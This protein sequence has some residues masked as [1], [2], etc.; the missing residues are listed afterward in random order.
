MDAYLVRKATFSDGRTRHNHIWDEIAKEVNDLAEDFPISREDCKKH[1][2]VLRKIFL[3]KK[4]E[5][6]TSGMGGSSDWVHFESM[7]AVMEKNVVEFPPVLCSGTCKTTSYRSA[8]ISLKSVHSRR[9]VPTMN[10][11]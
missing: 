2:A 4:Q 11:Y 6:A 8:V 3:H 10:M 5:A 9:D 7:W 1:F